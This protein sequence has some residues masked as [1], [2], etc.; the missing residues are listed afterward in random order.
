MRSGKG[1]SR[2]GK[3]P[4]VLPEKVEVEIK[5]QEV[6]IKGPKGELHFELPLE[7]EVVLEEKTLKLIPKIKTKNYKALWGLWRQL[8]NNA[9]TGVTKGHTKRLELV[10]V[11]YRARMEGRNLVLEVGYSHPVLFEPPEQVEVRVEGDNIIVV[12]GIDK[13]WVSQVAANIRK[14]RKPDPYKGKG[15]R[16]QGEVIRLKPGKRAATG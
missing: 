6:K 7:L 15:I 2:V 16:Y 10:G 13:Y 1:M 4:I 5:G 14:I 11:G 8:L 12:S 9:I 3:Q